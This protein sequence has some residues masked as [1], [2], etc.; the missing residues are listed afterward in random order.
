[1]KSR[2]PLPAGSGLFMFLADDMRH[3]G[4]AGFANF[5]KA[6]YFGCSY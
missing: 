2:P 1:M 5:E 4:L 3:A 6:C